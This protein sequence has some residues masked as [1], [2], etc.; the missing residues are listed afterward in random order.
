[1]GT[2]TIVRFGVAAIAA[3][4]LPASPCHAEPVAVSFPL[5]QD[6]DPSQGFPFA[7]DLKDHDSRLPD[8]RLF[9]FNGGGAGTSE[10]APIVDFV[11]SGVDPCTDP[12]TLQALL[13]DHNDPAWH[14]FERDTQP[15]VQFPI[16]EPG[17]FAGTGACFGSTEMPFL[18]F[19]A[20][21][22]YNV[23]NCDYSPEHIELV[24]RTPVL[25]YPLLVILPD[26]SPLYGWFAAQAV[27]V[28]SLAC[29]NDCEPGAETL[30]MIPLLRFI[31]AGFETEPGT[32]I[33]VGGGLCAADVNFDAVLDLADVQGFI[34]AFI[35]QEPPADQNGDGVYDLADVQ[36]FVGAFTTGCGF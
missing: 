36:L 33:I 1:M 16:G 31:G 18:R 26:E 27:D 9:P 3:A 2:H 13:T 21:E 11:Q 20:N 28:R 7:V 6:G 22:F 32:P 14:V 8:L 34:G 30:C 19:Y 29:D 15:G 12:G 17:V 5:Y 25:Y 23:V 35:A 24:E 10:I 4:I